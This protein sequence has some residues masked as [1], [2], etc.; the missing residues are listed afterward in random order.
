[1]TCWFSCVP[2]ADS[3]SKANRVDAGAPGMST[4]VVAPARL[5]VDI[6]LTFAGTPQE[7]F[8]LLCPVREYDW[9]PDWSCTMVHGL[10]LGLPGNLAQL[11]A[12]LI[13]DADKQKR[14]GKSNRHSNFL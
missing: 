14:R 8:A 3:R 12:V 1:M 5:V 11:S 2:A 9:I 10:Y 13:K 7:V 6:P 4:T